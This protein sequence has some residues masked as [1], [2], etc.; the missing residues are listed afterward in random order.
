MSGLRLVSFLNIYRYNACR[1]L[2]RR[3]CR[4]HSVVRAVCTCRVACIAT[5]SAGFMP[6]SI[7]VVWVIVANMSRDCW[8][9]VQPIGGGTV[10]SVLTDKSLG[11]RGPGRWTRY[12]ESVSRRPICSVY[13]HITCSF[14]IHLWSRVYEWINARHSSPTIPFSNT[15]T[16]VAGLSVNSLFIESHIF[17]SL[18]SQTTSASNS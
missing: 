8:I 10:T 1:S 4:V 15:V 2:I 16:T 7:Q 3:H 11:P 18:S 17:L 13:P 5:T 9:A 14:Q 6:K 12:I